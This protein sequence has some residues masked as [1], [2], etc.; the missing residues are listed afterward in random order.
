MAYSKLSGWSRTLQTSIT[1][2]DTTWS[3]AVP[4]LPRSDV[5]NDAGLMKTILVLSNETKQSI[6]LRFSKTSPNRAIDNGRLD[7]FIS[8]S[9]EQFRLQLPL[10]QDHTNGANATKSASHKESADYVVRLLRHGIILNNVQYHFY[11][12]SNSQL[13]SKTC[14]LCQGSKAQIS[15][16]VE[17]LG[18]FSKLKSVAKKAKRI[19]LLFSAAQMATKLRPDRC[20]DIPDITK[21]D[22]NFTDGCGLISTHLAKL[23]VQ[24]AHIRYRNRRYTPS[25]FQIRYRGYKGVLMLEPKLHGQIL[26]QFRDSMRKFKGGDDLSF[27]VVD[28]SKPYSFGHLNDEVLLL[29]SSL[30]VS[31]DVLLRKQR[32]HLEFLLSAVNYCENAFRFLS[33]INKPELAEKVLVDGLESVRATVQKLVGE[34]YD[35]MLNKRDEQRCRILIPKSRLLFGV[36]DSRNILKEGECAVRITTDGDGTPRTISGTEVLVTRNP[37]LHP[38]DLQKFR[39][40]QHLELSHLVDCIIFPTRGRRPSADLMS[41]GDLDGDKCT[42]SLTPDPCRTDIGLQS[43][44]AGTPKSSRRTWPSQPIIL[45]ARSPSVLRP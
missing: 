23:L 19:G 42:P 37:C 43:W 9:F 8:I 36:C 25:V 31:E 45:Q 11:G 4:D 6:D 28:C 14:F 41:G 35:K 12:H 26:A 29:L 2:E 10:P 44:S 27:S 17:Q 13:K 20:Q 34:E 38:G 39:A 16:A 18:D 32:E 5:L 30:G 7:C 40:V 3:Y 15:I 21:G 33:Y 1:P 22:Y 24:R